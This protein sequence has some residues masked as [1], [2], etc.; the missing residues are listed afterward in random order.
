MVL[1]ELEL[2][3]YILQTVS[4]IDVYCVWPTDGSTVFS[5]LRCSVNKRY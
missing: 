3:P 5:V 1:F 2:N 4:F